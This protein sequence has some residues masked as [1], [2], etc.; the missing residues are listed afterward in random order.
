MPKGATPVISVFILGGAGKQKNLASLRDILR[1]NC[2][3]TLI[4]EQQI[5]IQKENPDF[6]L[7]EIE[8]LSRITAPNMII[9]CK[10]P[11]YAPVNAVLPADA[12]GLLSSDNLPAAE[13]IRRCGV[14]AM[15]LGMSSKDTLT[16]S[17]IT[18]DSAVLCLQRAIS[19]LF[20]N[21]LDP[22]EIPL[23]LS[24]RYDAFSILCAAAIFLLSGKID[25]LKQI[26]F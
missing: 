10:E 4:G 18:P 19:D 12:V 23:S 7:V 2:T 3:L 5:D 15:T 22:V 9:L 24:H 14:R 26:L 16:L 20:G 13:F 8:N 11:F 6:A 25:I 1:K 17:S 21:T